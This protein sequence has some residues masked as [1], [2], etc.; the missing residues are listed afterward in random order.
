MRT[1]VAALAA[2]VLTIVAPLSAQQRGM[3][4]VGIHARYTIPDENLAIDHA[5]GFGGRLGWFIAQ[6]VALE[7]E[8]ARTF[9]NLTD[10]T[11]ELRLNPMYL[12]LAWHRP[13]SERWSGI[14]GVGAVREEL[15][16]PN[17]GIWR[18]DGYSALLGLQAKLSDRVG[19]R[20]D[21]IGDAYTSPVNE[22]PTNDV[23][24][25]NFSLQAGFNFRLGRMAP[26]DADGDGVPDELDVCPGTLMGEIVDARGCVPPKDA[27][28]DGVFD[29]DDRCP[30][31][32]RGAP[33]TASGC[34]RDAD[35]DGVHDGIDQCPN[36][37]TGTPV[38]ATG[39]PRDAD[40]DGVHDG[41]DQCPNTP[42]NTT[43][44]ADG[45][46][47]DT[48]GDGVPDGVDQCPNTAA[49]SPVDARGCARLFE[50]GKTTLI[51]DGVTFATGRAE[52]TVD[53]T[54][55]LDRVA[56]SLLESTDVNVE[57]QGH[58]D[59]TGSR[60]LNMR[61]SGQRAESVRLYLIQKGVAASRL[62]SRGYGP[63]QPVASNTTVDGRAQNR[64]VE[65]KRMP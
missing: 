20:F 9:T 53:A 27:D 37:P 54:T 25:Y 28:G 35:G 57:V 52:L 49:G 43:V 32:P 48:D 38:T 40:N 13:L 31:T 56:A 50:E 39:C 22:T 6:D 23:E 41:I 15:R 14:L 18:D 4:D 65:L 46:P 60:A 34:P 45:C 8:H 30:N 3:V 44:T 33:V 1:Y 51:L 42:A 36:T 19:L 26:R 7:F 5:P 17:G 24:S 29:A 21:L 61:L 59:I 47:R 2:L 11:S 62:T 55:I 58:T 16:M 64:R 10:Q 12:R 63:D